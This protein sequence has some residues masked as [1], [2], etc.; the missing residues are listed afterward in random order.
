[1]ALVRQRLVSS[2]YYAAFETRAFQRGPVWGDAA[3]ADLFGREYDVDALAAA[4]NLRGD[5]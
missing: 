1:M 2:D 4:A 3:I 5:P